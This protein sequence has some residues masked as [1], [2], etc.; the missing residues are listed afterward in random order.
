MPEETKDGKKI[1]ELKQKLVL[2]ASTIEKLC[3]QIEELR[4]HLAGY[5]VW[6]QILNESHQKLVQRINPK[7][8][9][10]ESTSKTIKDKKSIF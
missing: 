4:A 7:V 9:S 5:Q 10:C 3:K 1:K 6:Y 2:H 8:N